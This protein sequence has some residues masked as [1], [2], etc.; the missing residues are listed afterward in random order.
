MEQAQ[1]SGEDFVLRRLV[2]GSILVAS[3]HPAIGPVYLEHVDALESGARNRYGLTTEIDCAKRYKRGDV[4]HSFFEDRINVALAKPGDI[5]DMSP[6]AIAVWM[7]PEAVVHWMRRNVWL[8]IPAPPTLYFLSQRNGFLG[9]RAEWTTDLSCAKRFTSSS[10]LLGADHDFR[11]D[12]EMA[13]QLGRFV[14]LAVASVVPWDAW[15][16]RAASSVNH[17]LEADVAWTR[18]RLATRYGFPLEDHQRSALQHAGDAGWERS[19]NGD[20]GPISGHIEAFA[21]L[22]A[23][24][25]IGYEL[26]QRVC[27][28]VDLSKGE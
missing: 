9:Y 18:Y 15:G 21:K 7:K 10:V 8:E 13:R 27:R 6:T 14:P 22:G 23:A 1:H 11:L 28:R 12:G 25:N 17:A 4:P 26:Q 2:T 16:D 19:A 24:F 20:S 3:Y 5:S